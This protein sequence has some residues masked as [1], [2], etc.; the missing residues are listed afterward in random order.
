MLVQVK[1]IAS[2][3]QRV[4]YRVLGIMA[5]LDGSGQGVQA[6]VVNDVGD[7]HT[8]RLS[9]PRFIP[10]SSLRIIDD[11]PPLEWR[12]IVLTKGIR[13]PTLVLSFDELLDVN[14]FVRVHDLN[15]TE[16]DMKTLA[17]RY[18]QYGGNILLG[19]DDVL[20]SEQ[21]AADEQELSR[22]CS[23]IAED[24]YQPSE[25]YV[26]Y[27]AR[28]LRFLSLQYRA[29]QQQSIVRAKWLLVDALVPILAPVRSLKERI[30][31]EPPAEVL[32]LA[33]L[34]QFPLGV[35]GVSLDK[36]VKMLAYAVNCH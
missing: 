35:S 9:S 36:A 17:R 14:L 33:E 20:G 2:G 22:L 24:P 8:L 7:K 21:Y 4:Q 19:E 16:E 18:A 32:K 28:L 31:K 27:E 5:A 10:F 12:A 25:L 23:A 30:D 3:A 11:T 13:I 29:V 34:L 26:E 1:S 15:A 6:M